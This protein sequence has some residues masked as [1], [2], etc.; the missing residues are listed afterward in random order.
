MRLPILRRPADHRS[1]TARAR[2]CPS[3]SVPRPRFAGAAR[4]ALVADDLDAGIDSGARDPTGRAARR[5]C[6]R[7]RRIGDRPLHGRASQ[8]RRR[9]PANSN[10]DF[11]VCL[12]RRARNPPAHRPEFSARLWKWAPR[13]TS[14]AAW[15]YARAGPSPGDWPERLCK[16]DGSKA[17][18][19]CW[20]SAVGSIFPA[21][22]N[23]STIFGMYSA[24][25]LE[26]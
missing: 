25:K 7:R 19:P 14:S 3:Q 22:V 21:G 4:R 12:N 6:D 8:S 26:A 15:C 5:L 16:S 10:S 20:W 23:L 13:E 9:R 17:A 24:R 2:A 1:V 11:R 18:N